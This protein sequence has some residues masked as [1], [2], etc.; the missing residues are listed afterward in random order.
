M[1]NNPAYDKFQP[2]SFVLLRKKAVQPRHM[3][4]SNTVYHSTPFRILRRTTTN[5]ILVPFGLGYLKQRFKHEGQVPKNLCTLQRL[6][7]L[8]PIKNPFKL[9]RL[10]FSQK[11]LLELNS[12]L[13][14]ETRP[15]SIVEIINNKVKDKPAQLFQDFN[16]SVK[17][18]PNP[19]NEQIRTKKPLQ[20]E[21]PSPNH[22]IEDIRK[23]K[24]HSFNHSFKDSELYVQSTIP[25]IK[26]I[27]KKKVQESVSDCSSTA[28]SAKSNFSF[29]IEENYFEDD[30][31][32][33]SYR[34]ESPSNSSHSGRNS[35][36]SAEDHSSSDEIVTS[37]PDA[38][39]RI[40]GTDDEDQ[41]STVRPPHSIRKTIR[42]ITRII[43]PVED[44]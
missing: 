19:D 23:V 41:I 34:P 28:R 7:N 11:M 18:I 4:K 9:L 15:V 22:D 8:K 29:Q 33:N 5:A 14:S 6:S 35:I 10:T 32:D 12:L 37:F 13:Q 21:F 20:I 26:L 43:Y 24:L 16:A 39:I 44:V 36:I 25:S 31:F 27:K 2:G 1:P 17:F 3:M 40:F 38:G 42:T 30:L